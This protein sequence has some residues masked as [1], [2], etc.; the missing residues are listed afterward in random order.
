MY[1]QGQLVHTSKMLYMKL[2]HCTVHPWQCGGTV[3]WYALFIPPP[4]KCNSCM[5]PWKVL[6]WSHFSAASDYLVFISPRKGRITLSYGP[7]IAHSQSCPAL[8]LVP[9][10]H[11]N[12]E[13]RIKQTYRLFLMCAESNV[14]SSWMLMICNDVSTFDFF[15]ITK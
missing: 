1:V 9:R 5:D 10:V 13:E 6:S 15:Y 7:S 4:T 14:T 8:S 11:N 3:Q 2:G 12:R